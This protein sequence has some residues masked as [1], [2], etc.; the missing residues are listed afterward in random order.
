MLPDKSQ[1]SITIYPIQVHAIVNANSQKTR[2]GFYPSNERNQLLAII[3]YP[4]GLVSRYRYTGIKFLTLEGSVN[5]VPA[6]R[7][8]YHLGP[9]N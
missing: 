5:V 2:F 6:V 1:I 8:H 9:E 4:S 7:H 3:N